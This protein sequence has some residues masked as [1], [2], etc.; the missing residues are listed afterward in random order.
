MG[1]F[2]RPSF[3]GS[4]LARE[5]DLG[6]RGAPP[7][8]GALPG[9]FPPGIR[10]PIA[11]SVTNSAGFR[12]RRSSSASRPQTVDAKRPVSAREGRPMRP[13]RNPAE[14]RGRCPRPKAT[15][16]TP[17]PHDGGAGRPLPA[18]EPAPASAHKGPANPSTTEEPLGGR[19]S[20][21]PRPLANS[22]PTRQGAL[23]SSHGDWLN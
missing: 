14:A 19:G 6:K 11:K 3:Q 20:L 13:D 18:R 21:P 23:S 17:R 16:R 7:S 2:E 8:G 12:A 10:V 4:R 1:A 15:W 5:P 22:E 9:P